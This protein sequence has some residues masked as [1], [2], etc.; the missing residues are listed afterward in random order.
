MRTARSAVLSLQPTPSP[1]PA[2]QDLLLSYNIGID[3]ETRQRN[4]VKS[5]AASVGLQLPQVA[6]HED[7]AGDEHS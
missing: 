6:W 3:R 1:W 7:A 2:L 4:L 5:S